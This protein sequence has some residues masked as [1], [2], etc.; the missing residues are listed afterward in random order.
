MLDFEKA[1]VKHNNLGGLGP[2]KDEPKEIRYGSI[3]KNNGKSI[4]MIVSTSGEYRTP[5]PKLNGIRGKFALLALSN[6]TKTPLK[7]RF[8][9]SDTD[10][11]ATL[12]KFYLS[13]LDIDHSTNK[14]HKQKEKVYAKGFREY[15]RSKKTAI[16]RKGEGKGWTSF[17]AM[18]SG[19]SKDNPS[20]P[21]KLDTEQKRRVVSFM[22][23]SKSEIDV[24]FEVA[25]GKGRGREF[26]F[27]GKSAVV[28]KEC[29][30]PNRRRRAR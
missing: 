9:D 22:Y 11:P 2:D 23:L 19:D 30:T 15:F 5:M 13:F 27:A 26:F 28:T 12:L 29:I 3:G 18:K 20:D 4:D 7:I 6:G 1:T 21:L 8:V 14:E 17:T 24:I 16:K 10:K 25:E